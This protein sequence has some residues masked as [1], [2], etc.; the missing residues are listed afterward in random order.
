MTEYAIGVDLG[1]TNLRAA[2]IDATGEMLEK[3]ALTTDL[4][5]GPQPVVADIVEAINKLKAKY[6]SHRLVGVGIGVPGFIDM[7]RGFILG[8]N[9]LP[10]FDQFPVRDEIEKQLGTT[11]ILEN[12]ANAAAMGE[13]WIGAGRGFDELV[14][15]TLGTGIGGGIISEGRILHGFVGMAG[16]LG[17]MTVYPN[18][19]PCGCGNYGCLEKHA[20]ATAVVAMARMLSLGESLTSEDVYKLAVNGNERARM[21]FHTVGTALGIAL[22]SLMNIFNFPLYLL[23]GGLMAG[24]DQFAPSMM[25]EVEKRSFA[26]RATKFASTGRTVVTKVE[27]AAL[28]N[29]A[30]LFGAAHLPLARTPR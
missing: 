1:G 20:S 12:D 22:A 5:A 8:S 26:Y 15:L 17:H 2:A 28:G 11:V 23:S 27:K 25:A 21:I 18:G 3:I 4:A 14:L 29:L 13:K 9:N 6:T 16:E 10:G 7:K 19:N 24:W 30:G